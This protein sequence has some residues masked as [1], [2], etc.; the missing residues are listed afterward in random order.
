MSDWRSIDAFLKSKG[1]RFG[2]QG[3]FQTTGGNHAAGSY[4]Y[5]GLARDY[6]DADSDCRAIVRALEPFAANGTLLELFYAPTGTWWK[7]G[8]RI[9]GAAIGGHRDHVHAAVAP[10][11]SFPTDPPPV[12]PRPPEPPAPDL[13]RLAV[14][15]NEN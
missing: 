14:I 10:A 2:Y 15:A 6:G 5:Q 7:N 9:S 12:P 3:S 8:K 4:H 11:R 13:R 1:I